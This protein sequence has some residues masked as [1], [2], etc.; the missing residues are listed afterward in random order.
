MVCG[1][2]HIGKRQI[3]S[4]RFWQM[5]WHFKVDFLQIWQQW[6][7]VGVST[8]TSTCQHSCFYTLH[9][10]K[11]VWNG[12]FVSVI[13]SHLLCLASGGGVTNSSPHVFYMGISQPLACITGCKISSQSICAKVL[14]W[15]AW[16]GCYHFFQSGQQMNFHCSKALVA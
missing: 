15:Y 10:T 3:F 11:A 12:T 1:R 7:W 13:F 9:S 4:G 6:S 16:W 5:C 2:E 14:L 8:S